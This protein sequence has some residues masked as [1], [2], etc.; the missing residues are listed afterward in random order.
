MGLAT[1]NV[2][3]HDKV[4]PCKIADGFFWFVN[5]TYCN[6][7]LVEWCGHKYSEPAKCGHAE[8]ELPPGCYIVRGAQV[9]WLPGKTP[10]ITL[11]DHAVVVVGCDEK[12]CVHLYT[13]TDRQ[14]PGSAAL[15]ARFLAETQGLPRD[16]VDRFAAAS[17]ALLESM[18]KTARD[19]ALEQLLEQLREVLEKNPPEET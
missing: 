9:F 2:W 5:V 16:K 1:L 10:L 11:T 13:P 14:L 3:I 8:F 19:A 4:D 15:G 17:E 18:P 12:A 6:G 7:N